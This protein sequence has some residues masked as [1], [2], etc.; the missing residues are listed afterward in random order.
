MTHLVELLQSNANATNALGAIASAL[1][2][3][4]ALCIS[5]ISLLISFRSLKIQRRHNVLSVTPIPEITVG[6]YENSLT[7]KLRNNGSGPLLI[8]S[9]SVSNGILSRH[10]IIE[11][12]PSE[13]PNERGWTTFSQSLINRSLLPGNKIDLTRINRV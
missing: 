12:M 10:S 1:V 8:K 11:H 9:I 4:F 7:V 2:A 3:V 5:I 6:D 13:L